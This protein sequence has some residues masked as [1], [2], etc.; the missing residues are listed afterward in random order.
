MRVVVLYNLSMYIIKRYNNDAPHKECIVG[1]IYKEH[2]ATR[3][4]NLLNRANLINGKEV[5]RG[6]LYVACKEEGIEEE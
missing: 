4:V 6:L 3:I 1:E 5:I 2:E